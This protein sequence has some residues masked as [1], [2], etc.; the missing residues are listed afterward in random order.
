MSTHNSLFL[1]GEISK[2]IISYAK[3]VTPL[4]YSFWSLAFS[5]KHFTVFSSTA[6]SAKELL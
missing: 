3:L 6:R 2:I 1:Y 5:I 4:K